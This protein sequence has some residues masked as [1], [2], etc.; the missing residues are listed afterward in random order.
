MNIYG[1]LLEYVKP[2]KGRLAI[3]IVASVGVA[4]SDAAAARLVQP[5]IDRLIVNQ[6]ADLVILVPFFIIGLAVFKGISRYA[7]EYFIRT[8]GQLVMQDLRNHVHSHSLSM[9]MGFFSRTPVGT[10]MSRILNDVMVM[11]AAVAE[12]VVALLRD[13]ITVIALMGVA[14]YGDWKLAAV[15][16]VVLPLAAGPAS[17]I[18]KKIKRYS[19]QGQG[20]MGILTTAL[21]QGFSGIKVIKAFG[22]EDR[23]V[24]DFQRENRSYYNSMRKVIKYDAASSPVMEILSA[25]GIAAIVWYGLQRVISGGMTQGEFASVTAAILFMYTPAKRLSKQYNKI[26]QAIGAAE[27][28]FE[29]LEEKP[30]I[31][32]K[33]DAGKM[34]RAKGEVE[35][36]HVSFAYDDESVLHDFS[37]RAAPGEIVAL[38]GPSGA[39]KSTVVGLL[40]RFY[41]AQK[42]AVRIDGQDIR[43]VTMASLKENLALVDQE[44]FLFND[45]IYNNILYG[46]PG[47]TEEEVV[48]AARKA[49]ADDFISLVPDGYQSE[50]GDRGLRLSGG[51]R[52]RICIARAILRD[53]PILILDEA[54]S[55]L[56]TESEAMV[57][58]ALANLM[59]DRTTFVIAHRLS[60]IMHAEKIVVLEDGRI[61]QSGR[62]EELLAAGGLYKKLYDMQFAS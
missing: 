43:D 60:T 6:E 41:D 15:A 42:G 22:S 53:A 57:Q 54:T 61:V 9:S 8:C 37:L 18:G 4:G 28:V 26:Q 27:R 2:Y 17:H 36:D 47:A 12:V 39:G 21:E 48:E 16:F 46:R 1:R 45:S 5:F 13:G 32:D 3:S 10:L 62:H 55:A 24:R 11:Q 51:Q 44:T 19:H 31:G 34:P 23:E 30:A 35:F 40:N 14:F 52:Q 59:E 33:P 25:L 38:V 58:K 20:A 56:D 49:Y 7:Q 50:I 29:L